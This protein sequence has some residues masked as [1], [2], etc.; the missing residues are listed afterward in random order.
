MIKLH[1]IF[2]ALVIKT[3]LAQGG[4]DINTIDVSSLAECQKQRQE[5]LN[6][7]KKG[8]DVVAYCAWISE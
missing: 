7:R 1:D 4:L 3:T 6:R 5:V 8:K 2:L